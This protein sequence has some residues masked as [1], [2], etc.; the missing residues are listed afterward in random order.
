MGTPIGATV[1]GGGGGRAAA[2]GGADDAKRAADEALRESQRVADVVRDQQFITKQK[3]IQTKFAQ[4]IF[5]AEQDAD[6]IRVRQLQTVEALVLA[7]NE[8]ARLLEEEKNSVAQL[9]I[10]RTRQGEAEAIRQQGLQDVLKLQLEQKKN[11]DEIIAG[12]DLE[13]A[14]KSATTEQARE[15]LR[16]AYELARL[17]GQGFTPEQIG[18]ITARKTELARPKTNRERLQGAAAGVKAELDALTDPINMITTAAAGIGDAFSTSFK[19]VISGSMTAKEALA[20]FFTS[21]AD[22]FLDMA[23]QIIAKM[24]QMAILNTIVGLLP[25]GSSGGI[26]SSM[27]KPGSPSQMVPSLPGATNYSGAFKARAKGGPV[28]SGQTYMVGERGPELFVP[29]RSGTIVAND[30]MGGGST[31]VVVNVDAKG[32]SVEGNEQGANQLGR[33]ISAAVQSELIKQQRPG[34]ILAR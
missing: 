20:S 27:F 2:G 11:F 33:V 25:G 19:G 8:T 10:A 22:M 23:A 1:G 32:S 31:N 3:G 16:L 4:L 26:G 29:G 9:A 18:A 15:Q 14:L 5:E 21:V 34:G 12:L 13:L 17:Q 7:G 30:K 6:P 24:I 28:S